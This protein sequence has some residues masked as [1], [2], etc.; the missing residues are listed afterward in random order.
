VIGCKK[1]KSFVRRE[2][3]SLTINFMI[4]DYEQE[5]MLRLMLAE[6]RWLAA[7]PPDEYERMRLSGHEG[8]F[9]AVIRQLIEGFSM[10]GGDFP[11]RSAFGR[12]DLPVSRR[13]MAALTLT[14]K[15]KLMA[16]SRAATEREGANVSISEIVR[17][18]IDL[19]AVR[20]F[21]PEENSLRDR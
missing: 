13:R 21:A 18:L 19:Q 11:M 2:A 6:K 15:H 3:A 5:I 14:Q 1:E 12:F 20:V 7:L 10:R 17:R 9:S 16:W 4:S 8:S